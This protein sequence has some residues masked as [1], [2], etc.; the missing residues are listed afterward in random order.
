MA[1]IPSDLPP[2]QHALFRALTAHAAQANTVI[3]SRVEKVESDQKNTQKDANVA[4]AKANAAC[5]GVSEVLKRVEVLENTRNSNQKAPITKPTLEEA[6]Q[7]E[8]KHVKVLIS[9][10]KSMLSTVVVGY[11]KSTGFDRMEKLDLAKFTASRTSAD[12]CF[13]ETRGRVGIIHFQQREQRTG[14]VRARDFIRSIE[15]G[16]DSAKVW[17]RIECPEELRKAEGLAR[18]FG[19]FVQSSFPSENQPRSRCMDAYL[20]IDNVVVAPVTMFQ[21]SSCFS[22]L[23]VAVNE[24]L[25]NNNRTRLDIN[26]P[27]FAQLRRSIVA[28]LHEYYDSVTFIFDDEPGQPAAK[29]QRTNGGRQVE[30]EVFVDIAKVMEEDQAET[31]KT[32]GIDPLLPVTKPQPPPTESHVP[33]AARAPST[34]QSNKAPTNNKF[35]TSNKRS[36]STVSGFS[37]SQD[38][39]CFSNVMPRGQFK[40]PRVSHS[41]S[42][43][44]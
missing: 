28:I 8:V 16:A 10:A 41:R 27:L 37:F 30:E 2:E 21:T 19:K 1:E 6:L 12:H 42:I 44:R 43:Q 14:D 35:V 11:H 29:H 23:R 38:K 32:N 7:L 13:I 39:C 31:Q 25:C 5:R 4:L 17:A 36:A 33:A 18:S 34:L 22:R 3:I 15:D 26:M 24:V 9:K 40:N 20:L